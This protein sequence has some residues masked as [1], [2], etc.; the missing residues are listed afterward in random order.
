MFKKKLSSIII[1][2]ILSFVYL[3]VLYAQRIDSL[4]AIMETKYP[5][6]KIH[7]QF[8]K[9]YYNPG[10][11]IWFKAYIIADNLPGAVSKTMY[12]DLLDDR[13]S[14][15]QRKM[16]PIIQSGAASSFDLPDTLQA[17]RLFLRAYTKWM[18]NFDS[19][20]IYTKPIQIIPVKNVSKKTAQPITYNVQFFPESG[21]LVENISTVVA[22]KANDNQGIIRISCKTFL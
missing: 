8:D 16:M 12:A 18:L 20:L 4:L 5:Q 13:G 3:N 17:S 22:F 14:L 11:T 7:I 19:M 2:L 6:E 21:D 10:E 1:L 9:L 15:L